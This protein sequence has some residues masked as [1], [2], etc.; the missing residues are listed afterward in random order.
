MVQLINETNIDIEKVQTNKNT[1]AMHLLPK[2]SNVICIA[3]MADGGCCEN[4]K[5]KR[6]I[7]KTSLTCQ[8]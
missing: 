4:S 7:I 3:K 8:R 5:D 6:Y 2:G 1:N